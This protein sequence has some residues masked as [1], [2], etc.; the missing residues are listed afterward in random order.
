MAIE[1]FEKP[2]Y[3]N[4]LI[5]YSL[6]TDIFGLGFTIPIAIFLCLY[7]IGFSASQLPIFILLAVIF[8]AI[9]II[10]LFVSNNFLLA[11][12]REYMNLNEKGSDI[13]EKLYKKAYR[14]MDR[15]AYYHGFDSLIRWGL[16]L[17]FVPP[18]MHFYA[19][20]S[21][22]QAFLLVG[23]IFFT[24]IF[25]FVIFFAST[26][27]VVTEV[28]R[29]GLFPKDIQT[30]VPR[31]LSVRYVFT[32]LLTCLVLMLAVIVSLISYKSSVDSVKLTYQ[33]QLTNAADANVQ[34]VDNYYNSRVKDAEDLAANPIII[35]NLKKG[36]IK[37]TEDY[38]DSVRRNLIF[39]FNENIMI[40]SNASRKSV[41]I[42]AVPDT[43]RNIIGFDYKEFN[44][45]TAYFEWQDEP[46]T[47]VTPSY[48]S[49]LSNKSIIL[50]LTPIKDENRIIGHIAMTFQIEDYLNV[51]VGNVKIG[52]SGFVFL[53]DSSLH[54]MY[55]PD[56]KFDQDF[57]DSAVSSSIKDL[58]DNTLTEIKWR[59][60]FFFFIKK[61]SSRYGYVIGLLLDAESVEGPALQATFTI[62]IVVFIGLIF[63]A[64]YALYIMNTRL[65]PLG[66][67]NSAI[68]LMT[69]GD[70]TQKLNAT[71]S[72]EISSLNK[73]INSLILK[74]KEILESNQEVSEDMASSSEQMTAA[75]TSLSGNAQTQAAS[76]EEISAS[77][78]EVGA[79]IDNVNHQAESQ[80][81]RV[82]T[83]RD[84]MEEMTH[85]IEDM[86]KQVSD[87][88][89]RVGLIVQDGKDG[90]A[91]LGKMKL[92]ISKIGES[93]QEITSVV[94]IIT[95]I[96]EQINLLA[97]NAAIE[98]A[99]AG[100]YGKGFAVVADEI[101]KLAD[102][103]ADSIKEIDNLIQINEE[104]IDQGT[105]IISDT[106]RYIQ[107]ILQGVNYFET[108]TKNINEHM[109][110]QLGINLAVNKEVDGL[111]E[112]TAA[113][114]LAMEEQK[115]AIGEVSQAI[116]NI[117]ELT[118]STASGLEEM[119]GNSNGVASMAESLKNKIK[120]FKV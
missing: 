94:E 25:N 69:K 21:V 1:K 91:S 59:N 111:N 46:K 61:T 16:P 8:T 119:T 62:A 17:I 3:R 55:A 58:F 37:D 83:L 98:A 41:R 33:N 90:E 87:A 86:G 99:R 116:Y 109:N 38:L 93:S 30:D 34:L 101:G 50:I 117:N 104:E 108:M 100:S 44:L 39:Q 28:R 106:A 73:S 103:T 47:F 19:D 64:I 32:I 76:A 89:K 9:A 102:K 72:D 68:E 57:K 49:P 6:L 56:K 15:L 31:F 92:S 84:R 24:T 36:K 10:I 26:D 27:R 65:R 97:L 79:G 51:A 67:A 2:K 35:E 75:L 120:Y 118:Q 112:I 7:Y 63:F 53:V 48:V 4:F 54:R 13:P 52:N 18:I 85:I 115:N 42:S 22:S 82:F 66:N 105:K 20:V 95:S 71:N 77:I 96:S 23:I 12:I 107:T 40:L 11:P 78:E 81:G 14:R 74:F 88:A 110:S 60:E 114:K 113:I 29:N 45:A 70:L 80:S 5:K 43:N